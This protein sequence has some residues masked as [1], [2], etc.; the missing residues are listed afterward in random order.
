MNWRTL[1]YTSLSFLTYILYYIF[2]KIKFAVDY[3]RLQLRMEYKGLHLAGVVGFEP[4][5]SYL[6]RLTVYCLRPLGYTPIKAR[7]A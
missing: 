6:D 1:D 5:M 4:T 2:Q 3:V 7:H